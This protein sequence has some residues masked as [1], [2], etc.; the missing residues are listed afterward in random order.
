MEHSIITIDGPAGVGKTTLARAVAGILGIPFM[1]TGAMFRF[2]ALKLG[3]TG[4]TMP[5]GELR[6]STSQWHF[7]LAGVGNATQLLANGQ[8]IGTE[9]RTEAVSALASALAK[10]QEIRS[11]LLAAQQSLGRQS[12]LVAEGRDLG[13]VVFPDAPFK[14]FLDARPEVRAERRYR[15]QLT[16]GAQANLA[17]IAAAIRQRDEQDRNRPIAPLKSATD[18]MLIDTSDK[19]IEDVLAIIIGRVHDRHTQ[20]DKNKSWLEAN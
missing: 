18:A 15:E 2:L 11:A 12:S 6:K 16:K 4:L 10:R 19:S 17:E 14:F 20:R 7:S 3:E 5:V 9:I 8:P 1:D 13:T